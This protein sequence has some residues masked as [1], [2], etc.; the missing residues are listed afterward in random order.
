ML[1]C[2]KTET[3]GMTL[4]QKL[5]FWTWI[6]E[7]GCWLWV[8]YVNDQGYG[9]LY[10]GA[11]MQR[12][13]RLSWQA[14]GGE[15]SDSDILDHVCGVRSCINPDHLRVSTRALNGQYRIGLN[16]NNRTGY[17][18]AI[19]SKRDGTYSGEVM[20]SGTRYRKAGFA[21]A[22]DAATWAARKRAEVHQLGDFTLIPGPGGQPV[23]LS[24]V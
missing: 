15:L 4:R 19:Y 11:R 9:Q 10:W 7:S 2:D 22:E 5:D 24:V 14:S 21:T 16:R 17:R 1:S 3:V 12:A 6:V 18:G 23:E 20:S 8:G 13:H